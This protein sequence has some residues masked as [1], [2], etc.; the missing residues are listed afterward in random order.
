MS[1]EI[2]VD[3]ADKAQ[4][5]VNSILALLP[6]LL[7]EETRMERKG[8][9]EADLKN[10]EGRSVELRKKVKELLTRTEKM[11]GVSWADIMKE[12]AAAASVD[13]EHEDFKDKI[14]KNV[15]AH[16]DK[17]GKYDKEDFLDKID[18]LG[19]KANEILDD[20]FTEYFLKDDNA[21]MHEDVVSNND[22]AE[23]ALMAATDEDLQIRFEAAL[24]LRMMEIASQLE[25][26]KKDKKKH[27][28]RARPNMINFLKTHIF[29]PFENGKA[30]KQ[31]FLLSEHDSEKLYTVKK[32]Q[33]LGQKPKELQENEKLTTLRTRRTVIQDEQGN[34]IEMNVHFEQR[35]KKPRARVIKAAR[36]G[37]E[38]GV[39]DDDLNGARMIFEKKEDIDKFVP[40][41]LKKIREDICI[42]LQK[43]LDRIKKNDPDNK[44]LITHI[45]WRLQNPETCYEIL[46]EKDS[47]DGSG[48]KG[49]DKTSSAKLRIRKFK[50]KLWLS[51]GKRTEYEWQ[52]FVME[53]YADMQYN[54]ELAPEVFDFARFHE[55][56]VGKLFRP[57]ELHPDLDHNEIYERG[58]KQRR[59]KIWKNHGEPKEESKEE[60]KEKIEKPSL[61]N[62]LKGIVGDLRK[63]IFEN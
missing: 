36:N 20:I 53:G 21:M 62:K 61:F 38:L 27:D 10:G 50:L 24:K 22:I 2:K 43:R 59:Q 16:F 11:F 1:A 52:G 19:L 25:E 51:N 58:L 30:T 17:E 47:L 55:N 49:S 26:D 9:I 5:G 42:N 32:V 39:E 12:A 28:R 37:S 35:K 54:L 41:Y 60:S 45:E 14:R 4:S 3:K 8:E 46:E 57:P 40:F 15:Q 34:D 7:S 63:R 31:V 23:L 6:Y 13:P 56:G 18:E 48:F 33:I 29:K 44:G